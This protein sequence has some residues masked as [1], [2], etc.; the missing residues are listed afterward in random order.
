MDGGNAEAFAA[1]VAEW[2]DFFAAVAGLSG[3]LI[4]LLFVS[5][6]LNPRLFGKHGPAGIRVWAAQT[7]HS[8][9]VLLVIALIALIPADEPETLAITFLVVGV[10]GFVRIALD[11]RR[12]HGD[13][14]WGGRR[15]LGRVVSPFLAYAVSLWLGYALRTG[16]ADELGWAVAVVF[17]LLTSA[18]ASCWD[19]LEAVGD[20]DEG[21]G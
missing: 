7:F 3:T 1:A 18:A 14:A 8:F 13:P 11:L 19:L 5:L 20:H 4:G 17:F 6:S 9:L 21:E 16:S 12:A 2:H 10:Q 15:A